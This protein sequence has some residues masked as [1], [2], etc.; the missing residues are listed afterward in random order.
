MARVPQLK[1][2][3]LSE[4]QR[5]LAAELGSTRGGGLAINGPWGLLLRN[6]EL[7]ERAGRFGTMLRDGTSLPKRLSELAIAVTARFW[8][9]QFEWNAHAPQALRAGVSPEVIEAI[10]QRRRPKFDKKD[11]E[12]V[13]DYVTEL[14]EKKKVSDKTYK[15]LMA[16]VSPEAAIEITAVAGFYATVAMLIVAFEV[17]L[18]QGVAPPLAE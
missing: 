10:K 3:Q 17:D 13:Y 14:Y 1:P 2:E 9:A 15:T 8:T 12:A 4:R 6:E 16:H 18:P 5:K 11:E 7:C